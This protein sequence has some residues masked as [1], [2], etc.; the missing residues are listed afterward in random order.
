MWK[1]RKGLNHPEGPGLQ[2]LA[3]SL[4]AV[5][6]Q[7]LG[8]FPV[9]N[10]QRAG[11]GEETGGGGEIRESGMKVLYLGSESGDTRL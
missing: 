5:G 4:E 7:A 9:E 2:R 3:F 10:K 1:D 8:E 11:G 6:T